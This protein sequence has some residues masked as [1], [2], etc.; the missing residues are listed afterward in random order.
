MSLI[1][2][3]LWAA[4]KWSARPID[5]D[6]IVE[7]VRISTTRM[8]IYI[9]LYCYTVLGCFST[10]FDLYAEPSIVDMHLWLL[11]GNLCTSIRALGYTNIVFAMVSRH[12]RG[13]IHWHSSHYCAKSSFAELCQINVID[14]LHFGRTFPPGGR[15]YD[16]FLSCAIGNSF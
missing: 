8:N 16:S 14:W 12:R 7:E 11:T 5:A 13:V 15:I 3:L 6:L 10:E 9:I 4:F 2:I 1:P